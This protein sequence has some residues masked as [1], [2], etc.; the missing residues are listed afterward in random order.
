M[1]NRHVAA[2]TVVGLTTL[3][4]GMGV[5]EG[6]RHTPYQDVGGVWTACDG[7]T[8]PDIVPGHYY[9]DNECHTL[10]MNFAKKMTDRM[11][12]CLKVDLSEQEWVAWARWTWNIGPGAF[13]HSRAV[14]L[15][16][17][18]KRLEACD[19]MLDFHTAGGRDCRIKSNN[20]YGLIRAHQLDRA[21]CVSAH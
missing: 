19:A 12:T 16:N 9:T 5:S 10:Q 17:S 1:Q 14:A 21:M 2:I 11:G 8:G 4:A 18:G 15:L 6:Y 3:L 7:L 20:C 13:C